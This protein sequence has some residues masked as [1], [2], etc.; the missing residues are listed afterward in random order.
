MPR[1]EG[2]GKMRWKVSGGTEYETVRQYLDV[3]QKNQFVAVAAGVVVHQHT[4]VLMA[5]LHRCGDVLS[6]EDV[7]EGVQQLTAELAAAYKAAAV[8]LA[9]LQRVAAELSSGTQGKAA[10]DRRVAEAN[11]RCAVA[12]TSRAVCTEALTRIREQSRLA[13][14]A[15]LVE[16]QAAAV[17]SAEAAGP[18]GPQLQSSAGQTHGLVVGTRRQKENRRKK[19]SRRRKK[20]AA[21]GEG[22]HAEVVQHS[23]KGRQED[24]EA[25]AMCRGAVGDVSSSSTTLQKNV[26][27]TLVSG[28]SSLNKIQAYVEPDIEFFE[29]CEWPKDGG[30]AEMTVTAGR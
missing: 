23:G 21:L 26:G 17:G 25:T 1:E 10:V 2:A 3:V 5:D 6:A 19:E 20:E 27:N 28:G 22:Q 12:W 8:G 30:E 4:R 29:C 14:R 18:A 24:G 9:D 7:R 13:E 11:A 16:Q 15:E